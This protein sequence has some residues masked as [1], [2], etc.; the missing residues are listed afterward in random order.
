MLNLKNSKNNE[1]PELKILRSHMIQSNLSYTTFEFC[2][3][4]IHCDVIFILDKPSREGN[5]DITFIK[6]SKNNI[7]MYSFIIFKNSFKA[8]LD[9]GKLK[10]FFNIKSSNGYFDLQQF[11]KT[12]RTKIPEFP[13]TSNSLTRN[14]LAIA[15]DV[16]ESKKI[17]YK[18]LIKWSN[19]CRSK[20]NSK[21]IEVLLPELYE[22]IK[23][24][25]HISVGFTTEPN[26]KEQENYHYDLINNH[27]EEK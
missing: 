4:H 8:Y 18:K 23:D 19:Q 7:D 25:P 27:F 22:K 11:L 9:I 6:K 17:Y 13:N 21:K 12:F 14:K 3:N 2:Y 15:Y 26:S 20:E 10:K 16:P 1:L 5:Y 24:L